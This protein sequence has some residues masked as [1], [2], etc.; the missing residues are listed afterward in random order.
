MNCPNSSLLNEYNLPSLTS[1]YENVYSN[2]YFARVGKLLNDY[3]YDYYGRKGFYY[4][5]NMKATNR[6][7]ALLNFYYGLIEHR[8]LNDISYYNLDYNISFLHEPQYNKISLTYDL[9]EQLRSDID[10]VVLR[11]AEKRMIKDSDF[12]LTNGYYLIKEDRI[13][14]YQREIAPVENVFLREADILCFLEDIII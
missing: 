5:S 1:D 4:V 2:E 13:K 10:R 7:N 3:G 6:I 9:I 8:L 11:L 14:K 12:E